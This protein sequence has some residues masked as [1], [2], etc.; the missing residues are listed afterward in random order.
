VGETQASEM[1]LPKPPPTT[2]NAAVSG[3]GQG[4]WSAAAAVVPGGAADGVTGRTLQVV[5]APD[6]TVSLRWTRS[7]PR[8]KRVVGGLAP[9]PGRSTAAHAE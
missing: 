7:V 9:T 3:V 4:K 6:P 2:P 8:A 5:A 1:T